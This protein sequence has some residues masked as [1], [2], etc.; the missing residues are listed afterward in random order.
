MQLFSFFSVGESLIYLASHMLRIP[1]LLLSGVYRDIE[2]GMRANRRHWLHAMYN[3]VVG[4]H[5]TLR[6]SSTFPK[7][8]VDEVINPFE[9]VT[10]HHDAIYREIPYVRQLV[11]LSDATPDI[12]RGTSINGSD[13][14][15]QMR[16]MAIYTCA[17]ILPR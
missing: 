17:I 6:L 13:F 10:Y 11:C 12:H 1:L 5:N 9:K 2:L 16:A 14:K 8:A 7:W 4:A 3:E 15:L